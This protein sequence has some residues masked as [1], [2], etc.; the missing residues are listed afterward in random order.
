LPLFSGGRMNLFKMLVRIS[1]AFAKWS[2]IIMAILMTVMIFLQ[3]IFRYV[4]GSSLSSSEELARYAFIWSVAMGTAI[5]LKTRSHMGVELLVDNLPKNIR[6]YVEVFASFL[7]LTFFAILIIYGF[8]MT[9]KTM[10]QLSPALSLPM[11]FVYICIPLSAVVL[12]LC[13]VDNTIQDLKGTKYLDT[14]VKGE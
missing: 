14:A 7:N 9:A 13:E 11:G 1:V 6:K 2:A 3:V 12:F 8:S 5:A 10:D 4:I